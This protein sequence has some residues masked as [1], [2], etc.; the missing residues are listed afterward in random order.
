[1]IHPLDQTTFF[2]SLLLWV[3]RLGE[4][5]VFC[6]PTGTLRFMEGGGCGGGEQ[7]NGSFSYPVDITTKVFESQLVF[8]SIARSK[9][10][11]H[12]N[13]IYGVTFDLLK[14]LKG[15][16]PGLLK[17]KQLRLQFLID[18]SPSS[19]SNETSSSSGGTVSSEEP[20]QP[21]R[22]S[23]Q[24]CLPRVSVKTGRK[25]YVFINKMGNNQFLPLFTPELMNRKNTKGIQSILCPGC[26]KWTPGA[27]YPQS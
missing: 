8:E 21:R 10:E 27:I 1:M 24:Q 15:S 20:F 26:G 17:R 2:V 19:N 12:S 7:L 5:G 25:Y 11:V 14:L 9:S 23:P 18:P 3:L 22:L 13:G 6:F 4:V 16:A